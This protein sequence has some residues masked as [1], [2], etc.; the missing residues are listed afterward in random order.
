MRRIRT[1][2]SLT[3]LVV[4][5]IPLVPSYYLI[6]GLV[7]RS[8]EI[9][10]SQTTE[11]AIKGATRISSEFYLHYQEETLDIC[12]ELAESA[13]VVGLLRGE[14]EFREGALSE[15]AGALG[16]C[17]IDVYDA[18]NRLVASHLR[19]PEA[20]GQAEP[21]RG[22]TESEEINIGAHVAE[23]AFD[24]LGIAGDEMPIDTL[25]TRIHELSRKKETEILKESDDPGY[26]SVFAP[27]VDG[28]ERL[29]SMVVVRIMDEEFARGARHIMAVNRIFRTLNYYKDDIRAGFLAFLAL[30]CALMAALAMVVGY[31]LA[32]RLTAP[33]LRLVAGTRE[34]AAGDWEYRLEVDSKDEIGQ[35]MEAFNQMVARIG[36]TTEWAKREEAERRLAEEELRT[37]HDLQMSLMPRESPRI[38]GIDIVGR[39]LPANHVGGDFFQYY[40]ISDD[41]LA[42]SLADVT[43]HA[44]EAAIPV[45]MFSG[46]LKSQMELG[47]SIDMLFGR[48]NRTLHGTLGKRTYVCFTMGE[49]DPGTKELR[50][51]NSGCPYPYHYQAVN[52]NISEIQIDAYPLGINP[53]TVYP[54]KTV[55]LEPGD[56]IIFCSDGIIEAENSDGELFGFDRTAATIRKGC[57]QNLTAPQLLGYLT[58]EVKRFSQEAPQGDDQTVVVLAIEA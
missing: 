31:I 14:G 20:T 5:L 21:A 19:R 53:D 2:L 26:I 17:V 49:L 11:T 47:D 30:F 25:R 50:L 15:A 44:M 3:L 22:G 42:I 52:G 8:F 45:V 10:F 55:M 27:V 41:R 54:V 7:N 34:V 57:Q 9:G 6:K 36:E 48:L 43:G 32:R 23:Q 40:P 29:G 4:M 58:D 13:T 18:Q 33:L 28:G 56:R 16:A 12:R 24:M 51:S 38:A 1:K 37:A 46:I 35:L 39:C